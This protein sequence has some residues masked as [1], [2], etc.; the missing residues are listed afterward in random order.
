M[1]WILAHVPKPEQFEVYWCITDFCREYPDLPGK[2][3]W[4]EIR[5]LSERAL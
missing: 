5:D 1:A 3:T 4:R 2:R